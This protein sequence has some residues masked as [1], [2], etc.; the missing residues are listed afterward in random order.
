MDDWAITGDDEPARKRRR[1]PSSR[2]LPPPTNAPRHAAAVAEPSH[3]TAVPRQ[4][5]AATAAVAEPR[6]C[7]REITIAS[8]CAGLH[9]VSLAMMMLSLPHRTAFVS[10]VDPQAMS[11]IKLNFNL[12]GAT[13][14]NDVMNRQDDDLR[15]VGPV[16]LYTAG[17]PCQSFSK[18]GKHLGVDDPRGQVFI[19]L[20]ATVQTVLPRCFIF[21]N[22]PGLRHKTHS[23]ALADILNTLQHL[24]TANGERVYKVRMRMLDT[25]THG[26]L[27]QRRK[28]LF[29]VGWKR[30]EEKH[31]FAW[32]ETIQPKSIDKLICAGEASFACP[33]MTARI[34]TILKETYR[35]VR[36]ANGDPHRDPYVVDIDSGKRSGAAMVSPC[37]TRTR[38]RTG[39]HWLVHRRRMMTLS[40]IEAL[41]GFPQ[42]Y[43][44]LP[45]GIT[46]SQFAAMIGNAFTVSVIGRV[47]LRLLRSVGIVDNRCTD[48]WAD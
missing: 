11:A 43:L 19:R 9:S 25:V 2:R 48:V 20:L 35:E 46:E 41:Q 22:V 39:G 16:D 14:C 17:P 24:R 29:I 13:I 23:Q 15:D 33:K 7:A 47:A 5:A 28:R 44:R 6:R 32:P 8:D 1:L 40:E 31:E 26:G 42:G 30:A 18:N 4:P 3:A 10:E 21:E 37:L 38:C 36:L 34:Q 12:D 45:A 27:P